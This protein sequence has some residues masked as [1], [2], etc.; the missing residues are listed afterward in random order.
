MNRLIRYFII[1]LILSCPTVIFSQD[2]TIVHKGRSITL[3]S[4]FFQIKDQ[5]NYG[6]VYNGVN[7]ACNYAYTFSS[8][9]KTVIYETS[10]GL[11]TNFN[12]GI[13]IALRLKPIDLFYGLPIYSHFITLGAYYSTDYQW[14]LYPELQSGHMFWLTSIEIGP[15]L[16]MKIP[17][18]SRIIGVTFSNSII[19]L[20][21]RPK[22]ATETYFYSLRLLDFIGN[23]QKN[24]KFGSFNRFNHTNID[25]ELLRNERKLTSVAYSFEYIGY[26]QNPKVS[27]IYH[28]IKIKWK[29]GR[30]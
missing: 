26:Y 8:D 6:L 18:K 2:S 16:I 24:I 22:P 21:S 12:K 20:T 27:F 30:I 14:Q 25:I 1:I 13:G 11:G 17:Y 4:Q 19:N 28:S 7:L 3:N 10:L 9:K 29:I 23:A 5:F 15:Q